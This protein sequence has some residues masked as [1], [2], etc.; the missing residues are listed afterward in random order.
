[1]QRCA[2]RGA[3][4]VIW[5]PL[6]PVGWIGC[7]G[8]QANHRANSAPLLNEEG[9]SPC[10]VTVV[11]VL[12]EPRDR[13][14]LELNDGGRHGGLSGLRLTSCRTA[15]NRAL[16]SCLRMYRLVAVASVIRRVRRHGARCG[17]RLV[18]C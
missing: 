1:M 16:K 13:P 7:E 9:E 2:G 11:R 3:S 17:D 14:G 12:R 10:P 5:C 15:W 4:Q 18:T 6:R 8:P